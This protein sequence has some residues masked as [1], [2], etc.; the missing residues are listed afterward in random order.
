MIGVYVRMMIGGSPDLLPGRMLH[1]LVFGKLISS[2]GEGA[3]LPGLTQHLSTSS[4]SSGRGLRQ[5]TAEWGRAA[6]NWAM[7]IGSIRDPPSRIAFTRPQA[8][9][10]ALKAQDTSM[11]LGSVRISHMCRQPDQNCE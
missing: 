8:I 10:P 4:R 11:A 7:A 6:P 9:G 1:A 2:R 5:L 3:R